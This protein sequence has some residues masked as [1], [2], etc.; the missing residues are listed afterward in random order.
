MIVDERDLTDAIA[1]VFMNESDVLV[2]FVIG[3]RVFARDRELIFSSE[4]FVLRTA[5]SIANHV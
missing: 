3:G 4:R 1:E 5:D 2:L